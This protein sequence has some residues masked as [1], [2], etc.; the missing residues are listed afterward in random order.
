MIEPDGVASSPLERPVA[1]LVNARDATTHGSVTGSS[2]SGTSVSHSQ[3]VGQP[4]AAG[5]HCEYHW[6][7]LKH[8]SLAPQQPVTPPPPH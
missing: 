2:S 4:S 3:P 1:E 8:E 6:F 7:S 5:R